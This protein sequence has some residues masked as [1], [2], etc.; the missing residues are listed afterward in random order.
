MPRQ[1]N[2]ASAQSDVSLGIAAHLGWASVVTIIVT[3]DLFRV[4][5]TD[6]LALVEA[7]APEALEPYHRAAGFVD[8]ARGTPPADPSAILER[9]L[10]AQRRQAHAA[11]ARLTRELGEAGYRITAAAILSGR[12]RLAT[13]L[14]KVLASHAQI[15]IAEGLAVRAALR[16]AF[17]RLGIRIAAI[18]Q[19][20]TFAQACA[21][22]RLDERSLAVRLKSLRP[23]IAGQWRQEERLAALAA[24]VASSG[25][26]E[27]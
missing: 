18:E 5:R 23:E 21:A 10:E 25:A 9:G 1:R 22:L 15:H 12:G 27:N 14:D 3:P 8:N 17:E 13:S 26:A 16:H 11:F 4:L 20:T 19:Q 7:G 6:R 24:R 2:R